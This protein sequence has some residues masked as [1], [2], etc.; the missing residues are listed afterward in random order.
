M[1]KHFFYP[2]MAAVS[3]FSLCFCMTACGSDD[4][5]E[6][7]ELEED[8][9]DGV[10]VIKGVHQIDV[11]FSGD[12]SGWDMKIY[13][14][15]ADMKGDNYPM[16]ENDKKLEINANGVYWMNT[17]FRNYSVRTDDKG[18]MVHC[19]MDIKKKKKATN[20]SP[21]TIKVKSTINGKKRF[22]KEY[23]ADPQYS[24]IYLNLTTLKI[25]GFDCE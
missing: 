22:E 25:L 15:S 1:K 6:L 4:K 12:T 23:V 5:S 16:Y 14:Q 8:I 7:E 10:S 17:E 11:S 24:E 20:V 13:F 19:Y 9:N 3:A 21:V 18:Y 2:L